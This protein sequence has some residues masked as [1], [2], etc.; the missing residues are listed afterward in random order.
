M[1]VALARGGMK[2]IQIR[3]L[4]VVIFFQPRSFKVCHIFVFSPI[5]DFE[6]HITAKTSA[7]ENKTIV[8]RFF[9]IIKNIFKVRIFFFV[10]S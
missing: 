9:C 10:V 7:V 6:F 5:R 1:G 4:I 3:D 8:E 2:I